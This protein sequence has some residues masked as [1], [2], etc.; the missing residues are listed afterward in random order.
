MATNIRMTAGRVIFAIVSII[1]LAA[2]SE[3]A[4][5]VAAPGPSYDM[6]A[7][8]AEARAAIKEFGPALKTELQNAMSTGGVVAAI[9]MCNLTAPDIAVATGERHELQIG[10]TSHR[11]RNPANAPDEWEAARLQEFLVAA[12]QGVALKTL[13]FGA[14]VE[15]DEGAVFRYM[16]AIPTGGLCVVCHGQELAPEVVDTLGK[17]YPEDQARGFEVG[18]LRG[19]FTV[20]RKLN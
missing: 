4:E 5:E 7:L 6:D 18:D 14:V 20:T 11:V 13:D 17:L 1:T 19:A 16:K 10:R 2:C 15:T 9:E 12:E 3:P 8:K